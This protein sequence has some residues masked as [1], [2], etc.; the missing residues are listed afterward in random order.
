METVEG[1]VSF[2]NDSLSLP[3]DNNAGHG[4]EEG[5]GR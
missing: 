4:G 1:K 2:R 5:T 3:V